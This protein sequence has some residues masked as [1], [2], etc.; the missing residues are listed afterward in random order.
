MFINIRVAQRKRSEYENSTNGN[1]MNDENHISL[2]SFTSRF[3][4]IFPVMLQINSLCTSKPQR[5]NDD[6]KYEIRL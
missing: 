3:K 6:S 1:E 2:E 4:N 5:R